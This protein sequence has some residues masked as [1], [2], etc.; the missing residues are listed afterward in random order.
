M[1]TLMVLVVAVVVTAI[2]SSDLGLF[3][4]VSL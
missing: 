4:G 2:I 3:K 1:I